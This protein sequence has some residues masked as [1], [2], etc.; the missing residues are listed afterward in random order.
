MVHRSTY[1]LEREQLIRRPLDEVF[2]FFADAG[3][4]EAMTPPWLKFRIVHVSD[5]AIR[6]GTLIRYELRWRIVP[7]RW[8]TEITEW[9][10]PHRFVDDQISGPYRLWHHEH[11]F[12]EHHGGTL[13]RDLVTYRLPFGIF[14]RGAHALMVRRDVSKIFDYRAEYIA[15]TFE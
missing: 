10:P 6:R 12:T 15:R 9:E 7:L 5:G 14:G 3:N 4:L 8:T 11:E 1:V 13:M 2:A